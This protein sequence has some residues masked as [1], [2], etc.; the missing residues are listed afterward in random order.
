MGLGLKAKANLLSYYF[1]LFRCKSVVSFQGT[2]G[3]SRIISLLPKIHIVR[4]LKA[5]GAIIGENC[6]ID[7][8]LMLHRIKLPMTNLILRNNTHLGHRVYIDIT[9]EVCFEDDTAVGSYSMF[10]THAGD[11]TLNREDEVE[12]K[13]KI[14]IGKSVIIYSGSIVSPGVNIGDYAR[15]A[16][17]STVLKDVPEYAF[18]AGSPAIIKKDRKSLIKKLM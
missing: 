4:I 13:E 11:W 16:A 5:F 9:E 1:W 3:L 2:N 18:A 10:I 17:N 7:I 14:H 8:G 15:V 12:T 6:D